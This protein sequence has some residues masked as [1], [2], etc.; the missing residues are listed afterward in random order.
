MTATLSWH[1]DE[2]KQ[3]GVD[4]DDPAVVAKYDAR[5]GSDLEAD[6]KEA[7]DWGLES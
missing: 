3:I 7:K 1:Y 4:F 2:M 5:Q 6:R